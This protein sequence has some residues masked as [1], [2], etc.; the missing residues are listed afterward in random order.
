MSGTLNFSQKT[1]FLLLKFL[2]NILPLNTRVTD[3]FYLKTYNGKKWNFMENIFP[4]TTTP[5]SKNLGSNWPKYGKKYKINQKTFFIPHTF[6]VMIY[7]Y[8]VHSPIFWLQGPIMKFDVDYFLL[9]HPIS[10]M[11]NLGGNRSLFLKAHKNTF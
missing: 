9:C 7:R 5:K 11:K 6:W 10:T 4:L 3:F 8:L 1:F 2:S